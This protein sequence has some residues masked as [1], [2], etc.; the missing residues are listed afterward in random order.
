[1]LGVL[2]TYCKSKRVISLNNQ[3]LKALNDFKIKVELP[4][5]WSDMD[6]FK[7]VNIKNYF[8]YFEAA[9]VRYFDEIGFGKYYE[10]L[11]IAGVL[12]STSCNFIVPLVYPEMITVG[13]KISNFNKNGILMEHYILNQEKC[14]SAVGESCIVIFDFHK[15]KKILVPDFLRKAIECFEN[16]EK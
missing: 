7:H 10:S 5:S 14:L 13:A 1:M 4:V 12:S 3:Y 11:G 9:R 8:R 6:I 2:L 15:K 16:G